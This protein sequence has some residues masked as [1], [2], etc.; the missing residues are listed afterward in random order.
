MYREDQYAFLES[1]HLIDR[2]VIMQSSRRLILFFMIAQI[3]VVQWAPFVDAAVLYSQNFDTLSNGD[4]DTQDGWVRSGGGATSAVVQSAVTFHPGGKAL[5]I[6]SGAE[7]AQV[8]RQ[9]DAIAQPSAVRWMDLQVQPR[10]SS[11]AA[12]EVADET[13]R[14]FI[15][16]FYN[17][18][19][20][21]Y[22]NT[23]DAPPTAPDYP[24][25]LIAGTL[26][27]DWNAAADG[28]F[29][30]VTLRLDYAAKTYRVYW[31]GALM[32]FGGESDLNFVD[33]DAGADGVDVACAQGYNADSASM[34]VDEL[35]FSTFGL[36]AG[37]S[38]T[39]DGRANVS[40]NEPVTVNVFDAD[41]VTVEDYAGTLQ[42]S[43]NGTAGALSAIVWSQGGGDPSTN[44]PDNTAGT[45]GDDRA[46]LAVVAADGGTFSVLFNDDTPETVTLRATDGSIAG[47]QANLFVIGPPHAGNS[48]VAANPTSIDADLSDSSVVTVILKDVN[49]R[50]LDP[51]QTVTI[52]STEGALTGLDAAPDVMHNVG[53]GTYT[54]GLK[55]AT[56]FDA[57][58]TIEVT[59]NA[60]PLTAQ[61]TVSILDITRPTL[62]SAT[63]RDTDG[64]GSVDA[65]D[66]VFSEAV[67]DASLNPAGFSLDGVAATGFTTLGTPDDNAIRLNFS[68]QIPGTGLHD[69]IYDAGA[70]VVAD[71]SVSSNVLATVDP[72]EIDGA[73]PVILSAV[74][75]DVNGNGNIDA[76]DITLSEPVMDAET[77]VAG[78]AL[79]GQAA[80]GF[81][82]LATPNDASFRIIFTPEL[83]GTALR[84]LT[85]SAAA[86]HVEDAAG[87]PMLSDDPEEA[88]GIQLVILSAT[89]LD[90][91]GD[92]DMDAAD[93]ILSKPVDDDA[94]DV[95][96]FTL[97]G[98]AAA[99]VDTLD[100]VDDAVI[101]VLFSPPLPGTALRDLQFNAA[102]G[103]V[104][105][106]TGMTLATS[107]PEETDA[108]RPAILSATLLDTDNNGSVDAVD[109]SFSEN[110]NDTGF[111]HNGFALDGVTATG[112]DTGDGENDT[113]VRLLFVAQLAGTGLHDLTYDQTL[114]LVADLAPSPNLLAT[115]DPGETDGA[116]PRILSVVLRDMNFDGNLDAV[117]L[118]FS[119]VVVDELVN[120]AGF[121]LDGQAA[122]GFDTLAADDDAMLR[123]LYSPALSGTG[124]RDLVYD[125]ALGHVE[126]IAG[127]PLTG[128]DPT[129]ETDAGAPVIL[130]FEFFDDD[131]NGFIDRV[132]FTFSENLRG[133]GDKDI[134]DFVLVDA[135]GQT[136][137][138]FGL[139]NGSIA[140]L[141][142]KLTI[143]LNDNSGTAGR[144]TYA[145][146][147]DGDPFILQDAFGNPV[148]DTTNNRAPVV[149]CEADRTENPSFLSVSATASDPDNQ[150]LSL[151]WTQT[152][153][154]AGLVLVYA[155]AATVSFVATRDGVYTLRCTAT[156]PYLF[157]GFDELSVTINNLRP[158]ANAGVNQVVDMTTTPTVTLSGMDSVDVNNT[159]TYNDIQYYQ[160]TQLSGPM[161][162][163]FVGGSA[164]TVTAQFSTF[165]LAVGAYTFRLEV[166]DENASQP[167]FDTVQVQIVDEQIT[168]LQPNADAG[169]GG[170]FPLGTVLNLNGRESSDPDDVMGMGIVAFEWSLLN[171]PAGVHPILQSHPSDPVATV[172]PSA[173]GVYIFQLVVTDNEN[174]VSA[175][176][177]VAY[178]ILSPNEHPPQAD[179]GDNRTAPVYTQV[180]LDGSRSLDVDGDAIA[181][182]W[183]QTK[184]PT[185][186]LNDE[187]TAMPAFIPVQIGF[188]QF[189]LTVTDAHGNTGSPDTVS[190]LVYAPV[191]L[192]PQANAG[193]DQIPV[194][195]NA[196][197][198]LNGAASSDPES[199]ALSYFWIQLEGPVV[200]LDY[201]VATPSFTPKISRTYRFQL[202]VSDGVNLSLPDD[203]VVVVNSA[204]NKVPTAMPQ[205]STIIGHVGHAVTLDAR[206]SFD[207]ADDN[208]GVTDTQNG[209][210]VTWQQQRG[211]LTLIKNPFSPKTSFTPQV[212]GRYVIL[213]YVDD[214]F[215]RSP[216]SEIIV[217]VDDEAGSAAP[218]IFG[219][220]HDH[221]CFIATACLSDRNAPDARRVELENGVFFIP[222][223][224]QERLRELRRFRD[225]WLLTNPAGEVFVRF[226]YSH[227]PRFAKWLSTHPM[228][229]AAARWIVVEPA[230]LVADEFLGNSRRLRFSALILMTL[231]LIV[232]RVRRKKLLRRLRQAAGRTRLDAGPFPC[233]FRVFL[234][235]S[236]GHDG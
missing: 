70:G 129:G 64:D 122:A 74:L 146:I 207:P 87:L 180:Q 79:D 148:G 25:N 19:L 141:G 108:A 212:V 133:D 155:N 98:Q 85:Y 4:L 63:L 6:V 216:A 153:G 192:P 134:N 196:L 71:A 181:Y 172:Q 80:T 77:L 94:L 58:A 33:A 208:D 39:H 156:D 110:I 9:L 43:T 49:G 152:G 41:G 149:V 48:T 90:A 136:N 200:P 210:L 193:P 95:A 219:G 14:A 109:L 113:E 76:V 93:V 72:A 54:A 55:S 96:G 174:R 107:D 202:Y 165:G 10:Q 145:F 29:H 215:D 214:G 167:S 187:N 135:D 82:T 22:H 183:E 13:G 171:G 52:A 112:F 40:V 61:P 184:G 150:T 132:V 65:A 197:V 89:L 175:P 106:L 164:I 119:E 84:D 166:R 51:G 232:L 31:D 81:N 59:A 104:E 176:A 188:Y 99:G 23:N 46:D 144:P 131:E 21:A 159:P 15:L 154:P 130:L 163:S 182:S 204:D 123:L 143:T 157:T 83:P 206:D 137:L 37:I 194:D 121:L 56:L 190:I 111:N 209:L 147:D 226:Y 230:A 60:I 178:T 101:R 69:L 128:V 105:D 225:D 16:Y 5:E 220:G 44:L 234:P 26:N 2:F 127:L 179:A 203:V 235:H 169:I 27:V 1:G 53:D 30:R 100:T 47:Q 162:V 151:T 120:V 158:T 91:N 12:P 198:T 45:P 97:S 189:R 236:G 173:V 75:R 224:N 213:L 231:F 88:D 222:A 78:F 114:G 102:T 36:P 177:R 218:P 170:V 124:P 86:G 139:T 73:N 118:I 221:R 126:D 50:I 17:N 227:S 28:T 7:L 195:A 32:T 140:I 18:N 228:A 161:P 38:L 62:D 3:L 92:G 185:V 34:F 191:N 199:A 103:H 67:N 66:L 8:R 35:K 42:L 115:A 116:Y 168:D 229:R 205:Q 117:D 11:F 24:T 211:P 125:D 201:T 57:T 186:F 20:W 142:N 138:L 68:T 233:A 160:W 223:E 217:D